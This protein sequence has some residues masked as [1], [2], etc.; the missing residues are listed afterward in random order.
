[1][2]R[3]ELLFFQLDRLRRDYRR[4]RVW[5][6]LMVIA[7][8]LLTVFTAA[9]LADVGLRFQAVTCWSVW[10]FL[11]GGLGLGLWLVWR[12]ARRP[13]SHEALAVLV[14]AAGGGAA[15]NH[16]INAVQLARQDGVSGEFV[17]ALLGESDPGLERL[18]ASRLY[19]QR[20]YRRCLWLLVAVLAV[21]GVS[22][23]VS[24]RRVG[25]AALR[26]LAPMAGIPPYTLTQIVSVEPGDVTLSRGQAVPVTVRLGGDRPEAV[27]V[28]WERARDKTDEVVMERA[29]DTALHGELKGVFHDSRYRVVA[30]D[31][32]SPWYAIRVTNPPGLEQWTAKV[33]PPEYLGREA[34]TLDSGSVE[35]AVPVGSTV[36][37]AGSASAALS[38]A[39]VLQDDVVL[40]EKDIG[41]RSK[42][43]VSFVIREGGP[44]RLRLR[45]EGGLEATSVMPFAMQP[46][47]KP[48]IVLLDTRQRLVAAP[49]AQIPV[50]FRADDDCAVTRVGLERLLGDDL[51]EAVADA[52]P[53]SPVPS[54]AGRFLIDVASFDARPGD[55][56]RFRLWAE[57]NGDQRQR[58]RGHA[59]V[60][61]VTVPASEDRRDAR[62]QAAAQAEDGLKGLARLQ[63]ENL[64]TTRSLADLALLGKAPASPQIQPAHVAQQ[65]IR[66]VARDLL[67][68]PAA[69]GDLATILA[70]LANHEMSEVL[71]RF[72]EAHRAR[73]AELPAL[74]QQ[75]VRLETIILAGLT[76]IP[77]GLANEQRH[78][79]K[80]DLFAMLQKVVA[81]QRQNLQDSKV[82]QGPG[83]D[84]VVSARLAAVEDT[85]AQDLVT[86]GDLCLVMVAERVD[87][88]FAKQLRLAYDLLDKAKTYEKALTAA[89][90]LAAG[91]LPRAVQG[92]EEVLR[93]LMQA[94]NILNQW[95]VKNAQ[96]I[97]TDAGA[98][99]ERTKEELT[100]L[101][102]QQRQIAE[103]TRDLS[104][105]GKLDDEVREKLR[106]MDEKQ[107]DMAKL[108]EE[109]A[110]DL[111][112]FPELPVCNELN[113]KMREILE[114]VEQAMGSENAPAIEIAVQKEDAL[115]DAI[116]KTKERVEDVEMWLMDIPDNIVWNMESFDSDEFPD[117]PLVPLPDELED[118][119]GE[120]LDQA[121]D[122]E[123]QSQDTTG[124]N[125]IA[126]MEMGW[127][128]MDG[129]MPCFSAKGKSGN[130][131]PNDN[132]MTGRSGA[133][134]EGQSSGELVENHVKGL[135]G[136]D[137]HARR[138][139]DAFQKGMVTE[140]E[141]STMDARATGGGK[142]GGESET[143]GMFGKAPRRDLHTESHGRTP[144]QLRQ[145][146]EA[147]YATA[148]LLYLG[149]GSLGS[150]ARELRGIESAGPRMKEFGSLHRRVLRR[151]EDSHVEMSSGV[152]LPMP[153]AAVS[154]TGG[155]AA[156]DV[157]INRIS[158]EYRDIVSDYYR[159]LQAGE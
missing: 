158:E 24:P 101:E 47:Q 14:E 84:A 35:M 64:R 156:E 107:K 110:N 31:A 99:L 159:S 37:L 30:G 131:R 102:A 115:L 98:A 86:F 58:R 34:F 13:L 96:R 154:K 61:Q 36:V 125:M 153:V 38:A 97:V 8:L 130:A 142:L 127:A 65:N 132:E 151:L 46:D 116:R 146:T 89:E 143:I 113:S 51:N 29:A 81:A 28:V 138:T 12:Q 114:D 76:G 91:D 44:V 95:R 141:N 135:E 18:G 42:F 88:E 15:S 112:Q 105:R 71:E 157:D 68:D 121:A 119:V 108:V 7:S 155:A 45:G 148:R 32:R 73:P 59:P 67:R 150:A 128:V 136:R 103:V 22:L 57:D 111:Y 123:A 63:R 9:T 33:V 69:L 19:S 16:V 134:R 149:T 85:I 124:N 17:E 11:V 77:T 41:G 60:L 126:D 4:G 147:V 79:D 109:L 72:D 144:T 55:V 118:I 133:G 49:D 94:L 3:V 75:C 53:P 43:A 80:T 92:Q 62:R 52:A 6:W 129:P 5:R 104:Q 100:A 140:D 83:A 78:Q 87:D 66:V 10:L 122:I 82:A 20:P 145:E 48:T 23:A 117:M 40:A 25:H 137:T 54:F 21:L 93:D 70:N 50:A 152:V 139:Q 56:L 2:T 90:A 27:H 120:L 106:E 39:A 26:L 74:L 1:M